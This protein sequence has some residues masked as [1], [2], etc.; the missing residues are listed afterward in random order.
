L[1]QPF[2]YDKGSA[3]KEHVRR[4]LFWSWRMLLG[5]SSLRIS[6]LKRMRRLAKRRGWLQKL[7]NAPVV[8]DNQGLDGFIERFLRHGCRDTDCEK[9]LYCHK[10]AKKAVSLEPKFQKECLEDANAV[11]EALESGNAWR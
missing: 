10:W 4:G 11:I 3:P 8:I 6:F 1:V 7:S 9:C 5:F 2:G